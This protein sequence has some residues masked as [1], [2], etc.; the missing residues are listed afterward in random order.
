VRRGARLVL[1]GAALAVATIAS[2]QDSADLPWWWN[3]PYKAFTQRSESMIPAIRPVSYL[4]ARKHPAAELRRGD[5]IAFRKGKE[6]W[7]KRVAGLPDD[8]VAMID[9]RVSINGRTATYAGT[10]PYAGPLDRSQSRGSVIQQME[11][12]EGEAAAHPILDQGWSQLDTVAET[13]V[14]AEHVYVLG[15]NRDN[16]VDSR[17]PATEMFGLGQVAFADV[18]GVVDASN[19]KFVKPPEAPEISTETSTAIV[20]S[21]GIRRP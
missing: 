20:P 17:V 15:D 2:A 19:I 11:R 12:F 1:A 3:Y 7:V 18:Y 4:V 10:E 9:G 14:A 5:L 21:P 8:R 16:S 6:V 13:V